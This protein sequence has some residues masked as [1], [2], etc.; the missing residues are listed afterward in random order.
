[1]NPY[2]S[3]ILLGYVL[4][5]MLFASW[6]PRVLHHVD[7]TEGTEDGNPGTF[8]AFSKCGVPTGVLVLVC[9]LGKAFLPVFAAQCQLGR[10]D[11]R[12]ALVLLAPVLGHVFP[13]LHRCRGGKGIAASFGVLLAL[14]PDWRPVLTLA[15]CYIL[16][17]TAVRVET[18]LW[19]SVITYG[20]F[21]L[22]ACSRFAAGP[23][24]DGSVLV[25]LVVIAGHLLRRT[26]AQGFSVR[27][28]WRHAG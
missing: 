18:H 12:F 4:G 2:W 25:A 6:I 28:L 21:A 1:M 19:R 24:R 16:F 20:V 27:L 8:N 15:L 11:P 26:E 13:I 9:E 23:V 5:G 14:I 22:L 17:S 7:V 3:Y 10:E